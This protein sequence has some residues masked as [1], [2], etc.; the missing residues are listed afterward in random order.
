M[1]YETDRLITEARN[2]ISQK[3]ME[4]NDI[5]HRVMQLEEFK[6]RIEPLIKTLEL[7]APKETTTNS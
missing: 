3:E 4:L 7:L 2:V 5:R 1:S 6:N